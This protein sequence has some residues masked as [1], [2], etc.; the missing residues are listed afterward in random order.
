[1]TVTPRFLL[2]SAALAVALSVAAPAIA[3]DTDTDPD[4]G[5]IATASVPAD[6]LAERYSELA[7]SP[8]A[9][10]ELVTQLRSGEDF[11]ITEEVTTTVTNENGTTTTT[12]ALVDRTVINP[13]GPMGY[14]EVN[15]TLAM[16]QALVD[17]GAFADLQSALT[18]A[19]STVTNPDGT[20][21]TTLEGGVLAMRADGMGWGQIA[22][23]LGF[24]LGSLVSASN[25]GGNTSARAERGADAA[26]A[27]RAAKPERV[28]R[29]ER[30]VRP[31]KIDRPDRPAR[32]ERPERPQK[33]ERGR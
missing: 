27:D 28:A 16:A 20:T 13:N 2:L 31:E 11:T 4:A 33:P 7:G 17:G 10:I 32:P 25:N 8:E 1:M 12:T 29:A 21:T 23:E 30:P 26:K 24:N 5:I 6:R 18:G 22:K 14:G 9:A 15:I 19:S 3:Q